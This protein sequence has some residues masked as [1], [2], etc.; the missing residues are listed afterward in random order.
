MRPNDTF[1][2]GAD[3]VMSDYSDRLWRVKQGI[4]AKDGGNP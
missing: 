4:A 1:S 3:C 2:L